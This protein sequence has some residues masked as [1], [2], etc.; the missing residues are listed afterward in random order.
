MRNFNEGVDVL[1]NNGLDGLTVANKLWAWMCSSHAEADVTPTNVK[2]DLTKVGTAIGVTG[3]SSASRIID[4]G[5]LDFSATVTGTAKS[6]V[7]STDDPANAGAKLV[8]I[9]DLNGGAAVDLAA[10]N[11]VIVDDLSIA[12]D[13][14]VSG[15]VA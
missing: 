6:V 4:L 2:A 9:Q 14:L 8:A 1:L 13:Y 11:G 3:R 10:V 7:V 5:A 12:V 15:S